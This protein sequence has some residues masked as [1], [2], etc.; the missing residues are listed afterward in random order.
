M[1][2]T[3]STTMFHRTNTTVSILSLNVKMASVPTS[4]RWWWNLLVLQFN[5]AAAAATV[6]VI[7][8]VNVVVVVVV[9]GAGR[10]L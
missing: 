1:I 5:A 2:A 8:V 7:V 4:W 3:I 10:S 6:V 9:G